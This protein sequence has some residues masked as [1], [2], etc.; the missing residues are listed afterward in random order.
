M[1]KHRNPNRP[2]FFVIIGAA[3]L[4]ILC[5]LLTNAVGWTKLC[6]GSLLGVGGLFLLLAEKK[7]WPLLL[8]LGGLVLFF[9]EVLLRLASQ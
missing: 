8:I 9:A 2:L 7:W 5:A 3:V 6:G 4:L 1:D